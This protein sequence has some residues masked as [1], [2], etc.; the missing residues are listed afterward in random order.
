MKNAVTDAARRCAF[1]DAPGATCR[2]ERDAAAGRL[3]TAAAVIV[4]YRRIT[5][6]EA[7]E[8][9]RAVEELAEVTL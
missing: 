2:V 6:H 7:A 8:R 4:E 9:R 5:A 3:A 1:R